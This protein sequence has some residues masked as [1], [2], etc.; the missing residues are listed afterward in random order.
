[1]FGPQAP[2]GGSVFMNTVAQGGGGL[3]TGYNQQ[4][5]HPAGFIQPLGMLNM[6]TQPMIHRMMGG[7]GLVPGQ[8]MGT[9]NIYDQYRMQQEML[10]MQAAIGQGAQLDRPVMTDTLVGIGTMMG[11]PMGLDEQ[12]TAAAMAGH[13]AHITPYLAQMA[14]DFLDKLHGSKGSAAVLARGLMTGG[15]MGID[16]VTGLR[17]LSGAAD[18]NGESTAN[19]FMKTI[20][21][22]INDPNSEFRQHGMSMGQA[23]LMYEELTT[24]GLLGVRGIGTMNRTEQYEAIAA[25][26]G[27]T[28]DQVRQAHNAPGGEEA[29]RTKMRQFDA[30]RVKTRMEGL[31]GAVDAMREIFGDLGNPNAPMSQIIDGL[32]ALTQGGL[33]SMPVATLENTVRMTK[34]I[35]DNTGM[36]IDSIMALTASAANV[37]DQL[38]LHRSLAVIAGQRGAIAGRS[39]ADMGW[40]GVFGAP[41][42]DE[43]AAMATKSITQGMASKAGNATMAIYRLEEMV[44][45]NFKAGSRAARLKQALERGDST[46]EGRS[47][48]DT[49]ENPG[50]MRE[51][52]KSSGLS[53]LEVST[54]QDFLADPVGNQR[55]AAENPEVTD[56]IEIMQM[57]E[58]QADVMDTATEMA[59]QRTLDQGTNLSKRRQQQI[60]NNVMPQLSA[61]I[62]QNATS[63]DRKD[64]ASWR[65]FVDAQ[66]RP[67]LRAQGFSD[68]EID[69][70][71]PSLALGIEAEGNRQA[72]ALGYDNLEGILSLHGG[73]AVRQ[74]Q[75]NTAQARQDAAIRGALAPLSSRGPMRELMD[76][77][78]EG[79]QDLAQAVGRILGGIPGGQARD[80]IVKSME[81]LRSS[82]KRLDEID[83]DTSGRFRDADGNLTDAGRDARQRALEDIENAANA[84]H[85]VLDAQGDAYLSTTIS[86]EQVESAEK[87]IQ[88]LQKLA[89]KDPANMSIKERRHLETQ[90]GYQSKETQSLTNKFLGDLNSLKQLGAGGLDLVESLEADQG[91]LDRLVD[92]YGS[93]QAALEG[94]EAA[95]ARELMSNINATSSEINQRFSDQ[96]ITGV[97]DDEERR[98][99]ERI[100]EAR[101]D[102][103]ERRQQV[104]ETLAD[105]A[106]IDVSAMSEAERAT[107]LDQIGSG[108]DLAEI[109][110]EAGR[111]QR[112]RELEQ[113]AG[114][115]FADMT[116]MS[117]ADLRA[118]GLSAEEIKEVRSLE[119]GGRSL[120]NLGVGGGSGIHIEETLETEFGRDEEHR[121]AAE[122]GEDA[123]LVKA[124]T[125]SL[126][127]IKIDAMTLT[128]HGDGGAEI[129]PENPDDTPAVA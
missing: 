51:I 14:P 106:G 32:N 24:R 91:E 99:K 75:R 52:L 65:K 33:A 71:M 50:R 19:V 109:E 117:D 36:G 122:A 17:G 119:S 104:L 76:I 80:K 12:A 49:V 86:G 15:R 35:A 70:L 59:L 121:A 54:Y 88:D 45:G 111:E 108:K 96:N 27:Q 87:R 92:K 34:A 103:E 11:M 83:G 57:Q 95:R 1:M 69:R 120:A 114:Q 21:D 47:I 115:Q 125:S 127:N 30:N 124:I 58:S 101:T 37:G 22:A 55:Y 8:F 112:R 116:T 31:A 81:I 84:A 20:R 77:A 94:P 23:G 3:F 18:A 4:P 123:P 61:G 28:V 105:L 62:W 64:Q 13:L 129:A 107:I 78:Q 16:S 2:V 25:E 41:S 118:A 56:A 38:G 93:M 110:R 128:I 42:A 100:D 6:F 126:K 43:A 46:F 39:V 98:A 26:T 74:R 85:V 44:G 53:D 113:K 63:D 5:G 79:D 40:A 67:L 68:A 60:V 89:A 90:A 66:A 48:L 29:F 97:T 7:A 102:P 72:A 9:Q 73:Q 10:Q 82:R